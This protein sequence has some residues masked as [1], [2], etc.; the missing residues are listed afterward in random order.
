M[1]KFT[2]ALT[3][4]AAGIFPLTLSTPAMA[5]DEVVTVQGPVVVTSNTAAITVAL[6]CHAGQEAI[7]NGVANRVT[8]DGDIPEFQFDG[9]APVQCSGTPQTVRLDAQL[10][11][12]YG[13][14]PTV[15][16][17][18]G[19][20]V[21]LTYVGAE[22]PSATAQ[23]ERSGYPI[24]VVQPA[25]EPPVVTPRPPSAPRVGLGARTARSITVKWVGPA[26]PNGR[27]I[28]YRW[29]WTS[30]SAQWTRRYLTTNPALTHPFVIRNLAPR[31]RYTISLQ[32]INA[33]GIGARGIVR[34][35][36]PRL[37]TRPSAPSNAAAKAGSRRA[38]LTWAYPRSNGGAAITHYQVRRGT[39]AARN[40]PRTARRAV[41]T[42]L[43][44]GHRYSFYVRAHNRQGFGRWA[45]AARGRSWT[46]QR[47]LH[48]RCAL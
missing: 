25:P 26:R 44:N 33:A 34:A 12:A 37:I 42:G 19:Y 28:A 22:L 40:V 6:T 45:R 8:G 20:V 38:T 39:S 47:Y 35:T 16:T 24:L 46:S 41:F 7:L 27:I 10:S 30:P 3:S 13:P 17:D 43:R 31:T 15:D 23:H 29:T 2:A 32:A 9:S 18:G 48:C 14:S 1:F 11:P 4:V 36:T 5:D 21:R